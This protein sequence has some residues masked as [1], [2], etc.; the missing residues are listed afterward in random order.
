MTLSSR[1]ARSRARDSE[2]MG[3]GAQ[4]P[5]RRRSPK[6]VSIE[7][8]VRR[9]FVPEHPRTSRHAQDADGP[10]RPVAPDEVHTARRGGAVRI[11]REDRGA[12]QG[13]GISR[14]GPGCKSNGSSREQVRDHN[15]RF[16]NAVDALVDVA[17]PNA[18]AIAVLDNGKPSAPFTLAKEQADRRRSADG[19]CPRESHSRGEVAGSAGPARSVDGPQNAR[20]ADA[21][22]NAQQGRGE[23]NLQKRVTPAR[24]GG[25]PRTPGGT[26]TTEDAAPV[27]DKTSLRSYGGERHGRSC[28]QSLRFGWRRALETPRV[29][30][31]ARR[32]PRRPQ[33]CADDSGFAPTVS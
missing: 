28:N 7:P 32:R 19:S 16:D 14:R 30:Q 22:Q 15:R 21:S 31:K 13:Q 20:Y 29:V 1:P 23:Q 8:A 12:A 11:E 18:V 4:R 9:T 25:W 24:L 27:R 26:P 3:D 17:G 10:L 33:R 5:A 6:S 2:S